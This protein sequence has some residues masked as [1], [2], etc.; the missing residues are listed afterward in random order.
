M[1]YTYEY[2][3]PALTVDCVIFGLDDEGLKVLLIERAREP[4]AGQWAFP[5]GFIDVGETPEQAAER[6]LEEETGL[7]G[8]HLE[9]LHTFGEPD[10]DPREHVVSVVHYALV[11]VRGRR[12]RAAD[13]ARDVG[14]FPVLRPPSLAFDHDKILGMAHQRLQEKG[15]RQPI[16]LEL[17]PREFTLS[18]LLRLYEAILGRQLDKR[19]FR[20]RMWKTDLLVQTSQ[21][22]TRA[23]GRAARLY[24]FDRKEY[25]RL[26]ERGFC[27]QI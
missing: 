20:R 14:W 27:L 12:I 11:N 18:Q 13:D 6:E 2:P 8:V 15:R 16:G 26:S 5:G 9:Q 17:L 4:F 7:A 23:G 19:R 10:R 22:E 24:R 25:R 21:S 3:R 1:P